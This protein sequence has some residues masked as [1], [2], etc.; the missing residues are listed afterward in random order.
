[1][2]RTV[3]LVSLL[4]AVVASPVEAQDPTEIVRAA[5]DHW[6]GESNA[7]GANKT[8]KFSSNHDFFTHK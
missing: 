6:R 3:A 1:M 2:N 7:K 8:E 4:M 5:W